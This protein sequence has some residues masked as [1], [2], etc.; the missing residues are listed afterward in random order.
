M[1]YSRAG[2]LLIPSG[3]AVDPNRRHLHVICNDTDANGLNLL[4]AVTSWTSDLC[5]PTCRLEAH[6]HPWLSHSS[7]VLYRKAEV[8]EAVK[9]DAGI[10]RGL[11]TV[12]QS[13]NGQTF[14]RI[15]KGICTSPQTP[16]KIK[17]YFGCP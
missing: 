16:R 8:R 14:L 10:Q 2:T 4:V 5:D 3:P 6:E 1:T 13:M 9:L 7:Y 12:L 15:R 11:F 17:R